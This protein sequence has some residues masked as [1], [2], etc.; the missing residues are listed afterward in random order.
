MVKNDSNLTSLCSQEDYNNILRVFL[1]FPFNMENAEVESFNI[2]EKGFKANEKFYC[3]LNFIIMFIPLIIQIFLL[4]YY[5]MFS[6]R[7]KKGEII[8][9]LTINEEKDMK[10]NKYLVHHQQKSNVNNIKINLPKWYK[11][12]NEYFNLIKNGAELFTNNSKESNINN[13]NNLIFNY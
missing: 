3:A 6:K 1:D 12:L 8:N 4:I 7:Y 13:I 11:F 5:S 9:K 2:T 10:Q